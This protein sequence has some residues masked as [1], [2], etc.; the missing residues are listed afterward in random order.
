MELNKSRIAKRYASSFIDVVKQTEYKPLL[1]QL[2]SVCELLKSHPEL[3]KFAQNPLIDLESRIKVVTEVFTPLK[4]NEIVTNFID[5][6]LHNSRLDIL[7]LITF[8][9]ARMVRRKLKESLAVVYS[10]TKLD[11]A[12]QKRISDQLAK[13]FN[14]SITLDCKQDPALI[15]GLRIQISNKIIDFSI[16]GELQRINGALKEEG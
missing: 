13:I 16:Q 15:G 4:L 7:D 8:F 5:V 6:L 1:T 10:V 3:V 11:A 12:M 2:E 14:T 9:Y